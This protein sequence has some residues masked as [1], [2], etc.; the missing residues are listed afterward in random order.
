MNHWKILDKHEKVINCYINEINKYNYQEKLSSLYNYIKSITYT[1]YDGYQMHDAYK[2]IIEDVVKAEATFPN[3]KKFS[4]PVN[5][6]IKNEGNPVEKIVYLTRTYLVNEHSIYNS[7]N[8]NTFNFTNDC[9]EASLYIKKMCDDFKLE[10][11]ILPIYPGYDEMTA[12]FN[13]DGYHFANIV[14]FD[15]KYYLI[16]V[17]YSQ[18]FYQR[19]NNLDRLGLVGLSGCR[20]GT[21]ALMTDK[22]KSLAASLLQDGYIELDENTLKIYLDPF[23]ISFRNGL[24]Y[25]NTNDFSYTTNY[26]ALDYTKFLIGEDNQINHEGLENLGFQKRPIKDYNMKFNK[27]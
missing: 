18:F 8:I 22:G 13:G 1:Y 5:F 3:L 16:D 25:E 23:T 15:N 6:G 20:V 7:G 14:K 19:Q 9:K 4:V 12:L 11:Y 26:T 21:F 17:T 10:N 24:Y 27:R 2:C